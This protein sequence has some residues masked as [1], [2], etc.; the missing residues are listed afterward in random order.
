[1]D[2]SA[3]GRLAVFQGAS[4]APL[5]ARILSSQPLRDSRAASLSAK[6]LQQLLNTGRNKLD[7]DTDH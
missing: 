1:M 7:S 5:S 2:G 4:E 3:A 6:G